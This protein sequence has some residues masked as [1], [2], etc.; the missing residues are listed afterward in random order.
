M[1]KFMFIFMLLLCTIIGASQN[2]TLTYNA[3]QHWSKANLLMEDAKNADSYKSAISEFEQ[4]KSLCPD[5][6]DTYY[7]LAMLYN[8]IAD[9]SNSTYF[10][11]AARALE[12]YVSL[13]PEDKDA[14]KLADDMRA[15]MKE[16]NVENIKINLSIISSKTYRL[17][18]VFD[19]NGK[20]GIICSLDENGLHGIV[21]S[22]DEF[23]G[24]YDEA[25]KWVARNF[26]EGW[27][28]PTEGDLLEILK[29][30]EFL[31]VSF[32]RN[33]CELASKYWYWTSTTD[34]IGRRYV[35]L[36]YSYKNDEKNW[37]SG[38]YYVASTTDSYFTRAIY[39][40]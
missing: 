34:S 10:S 4:V 3:Q 31:R 12:K 32:I 33:N 26:P 29:N 28:L 19:G 40:F 21:M 1:K 6:P 14:V 30:I 15:K 25:V 24:T 16:N 9:K 20:K 22:I 13:C 7:N 8:A 2:S 37:K 39:K 36:F 23:R 17:G 18:D 11:K 5:Y 35:I 38:S 27:N